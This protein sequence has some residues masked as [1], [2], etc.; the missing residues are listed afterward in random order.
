MRRVK[1]PRQLRWGRRLVIGGA[2]AF[3]SAWIGL[4]VAIFKAIGG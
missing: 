4:S 1:T 2:S 3:I